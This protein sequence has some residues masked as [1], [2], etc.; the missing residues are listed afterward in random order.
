MPDDLEPPSTLDRRRFLTVLGVTAGGGA[1]ALSGCSTDR[2]QKLVPYLV[3]SEDQVPG[4][5]TWYASTCTECPSGCGVHVRTREGRAVKLEGNPEHPVNRG[6]LCSK[7]QAS[8]Q[9]LY[10]PGRIKAPMART[11]DGGFAE[12]TWD[13][14]IE[15]LAAKLNEAGSKVAVISGASRGTFGDLLAEWTT[16]LGGRLVRHESFDHE[17]VRAANRQV[18]GLDEVP[19]HDFGKAKYIISFGADFLESWGSP[20]EHQ[21]G[22]ARSHGFADG[23][24]ARFVYAAPRRDLTGLNA[25]EWVPIKPGSEAAL[26][27][28]MASVLVRERSDDRAGLAAAL[29]SFTPAMAAQETGLSAAT[30]ERLAR[31]FAAA[32]PSLAVAGGIGSQHAASTEVCVAVNVLNFV[33]GNVGE[34]VLFGAGMPMADGHGALAKLAQSMEGGEIAVALVHDANPAYTL[35]KSSGFAARFAKV[36]FKVSISS[37]LDETAALCDLLLPQHHALERWDDS[38]P[39]A[40]VHGLMQPVMEPVFNTLAAGEILL[41]LSRKAAG[42]LARFAAPTWEEHLKSRWR[43]LATELGEGDPVAF[44]HSAVQRGGV[45]RDP[46]APPQVALALADGRLAYTKPTFEGDG[47]FTFLTYP[48]AMLHDGRGTN[49]P[50]LL[51]NADPVTKITWHSWVEVSPAAATRLDVRDGE[52]VELTSPYGKVEAPVYVYPGIRDDAVAI[53]LGFGHTAY[54]TFAQGRGVNALDLLGAPRG[55]FVPYLSTKVSVQKT[56]RYRKLASVAGVPRQLGRGIAQAMP[57]EAAKRG[58][59]V[60]QARAEEGHAH[61]EINT[62]RELEA[63]HGWGEAQKRATQH[64]DYANEHPQWGMSI[65]LAKCTG[66]SACVTACYAENNIPT[67]GESEVL[68]GREMTWLRI[69]RYWEDAGHGGSEHG[70][71]GHGPQSSEPAAAPSAR[72]VPM[73]CQHCGN[74]PCEPVCPVYAAYHTADGLNG[75]VYNRCVGTRYCANNCPYKVRYF[76]WYKYNEQ[77]WPEPLHLQLNPDVTVRAR[78]V[79]EKCTFCIQR[80]RDT[81]NH[82]RLEDRPIRDGE[83]TTA[84]AQACPSDAIV[85]GNVKDPGSKVARIKQDARGY[86][87]L[88]EI[89]VRPAV[90][91][92]AKV[93]HPVEA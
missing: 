47:A 87:V 46:P 27:L 71:G 55:E 58:L 79:M 89:N 40:G 82:A 20:I 6:K 91:Y 84:C 44:W 64:G 33:A 53:P 10:N 85:F 19:A 24:V 31:E 73:L 36:G 32:R 2:V 81:Q 29:G 28:A 41:R 92:L 1:M 93:L 7:G 59:T 25:D 13:K 52:I 21:R 38:R 16:A 56:G 77:A 63:I 15:R 76:N 66:C 70:E 23:D 8:L 78:G 51:E 17:P 80:I 11:A 90:T 62:E 61:H 57:L 9:G 83:F 30:I 50:W 86:H 18:F 5:A 67:V 74:A 39:R 75:Q 42:P 45:F 65:D 60:Q 37:Y 3:Q 4:V 69:E 88:E 12:I 72:F 43:D 22:F 34:T 68:R 35:P 49:K 54:G 48:H 14:A 26:A